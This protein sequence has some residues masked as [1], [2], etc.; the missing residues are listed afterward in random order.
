MRLI[1]LLIARLHL[2]MSLRLAK[3]AAKELDRAHKQ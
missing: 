3:L 1:R 2:R